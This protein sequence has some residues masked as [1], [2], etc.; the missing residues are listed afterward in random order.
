MPTPNLFDRLRSQAAH[1]D[2]FLAPAAADQDPAALAARHAADDRQQAAVQG[3]VDRDLRSRS[4]ALAR[5][6]PASVR[7]AALARLFPLMSA[8]MAER[9]AARMNIDAWRAARHQEIQIDQDALNRRREQ[10]LAAQGQARE[11]VGYLTRTRR[12]QQERVAEAKP[13]RP[14]VDPQVAAWRTDPAS[15]NSFLK[16]HADVA[17]GDPLVDLARRIARHRVRLLSAAGR[18]RARVQRAVRSV[19]ATERTAARLQRGHL[20]TELS[21]PVERT[22]KGLAQVPRIAKFHELARARALKRELRCAKRTFRLKSRPF[23]IEPLHL[24]FL[25]SDGQAIV[26]GSG[27]VDLASPATIRRDL[28][29][30]GAWSEHHGRKPFKYLTEHL[31]ISLAPGHAAAGHD[32][33]A[34]ELLYRSHRAAARMG[35]DL[36]DHRY[37]IVQHTDTPHPHCHL[38]FSRLRTSDSACMQIPH[39]HAWRALAIDRDVQD[40]L[41]FGEHR[42]P[43]D[44][45]LF[46]SI[47]GGDPASMAASAA[48]ERG[49]AHGSIV[50]VGGRRESY[51]VYG[52]ATADRIGRWVG[53]QANEVAV[54]GGITKLVAQHRDLDAPMGANVDLV[55]YILRV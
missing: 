36:R 11:L 15:F 39:D 20:L 45:T 48:L 5:H 52:Q 54:P 41:F 4:A 33:L 19:R 24:S 22:A 44:E 9:A 13:R 47:G 1:A 51:P 28:A 38:V 6:L 3:R 23:A 29:D 32:A 43:Q 27:G 37:L 17:P 18:G 31:I 14:S 26:I 50:H 42:M 49:D 10:L 55:A 12:H 16:A 21:R 7:T 2:Q 46:A 40:S 35:I 34:A 53:R 8:E 25:E 30:I